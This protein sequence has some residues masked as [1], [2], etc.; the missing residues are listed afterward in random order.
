MIRKGKQAGHALLARQQD[1]IVML[2]AA[3]HLGAPQARPFAA[4]RVT[5]GGW[6]DKVSQ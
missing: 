5:R 1:S 2:S 3:K 6:G 4:L